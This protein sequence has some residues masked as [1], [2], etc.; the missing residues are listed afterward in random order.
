MMQGMGTLLCSS[1]PANI[2]GHTGF[3][4]VVDPWYLATFSSSTGLCSLFFVGRHERPEGRPSDHERP[5]GIQKAV[6]VSVVNMHVT[7][8]DDSQMEWTGVT[9]RI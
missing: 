5:R 4:P 8:T 7:L 1:T 6:A 3:H 2:V 9:V